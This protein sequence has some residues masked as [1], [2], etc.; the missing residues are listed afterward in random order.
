MTRELRDIGLIVGAPGVGKTTTLR[1]YREQN[2]NT[3]YCLMNPAVASMSAALQ[4]ICKALT[5]YSPQRAAEI[6]HVMCNATEW[7]QGPE[8]LIIDEA[9]HLNDLTLDSLRCV[10]DETGLPIV[11]AGNHTLRNRYNNTKRASF[12]QFTSRIGPKL[13]LDESTYS[14]IAALAR[15]HGVTDR[16]AVAFLER[17]S[18]HAGLRYVGKLLAIAGKGGPVTLATLKEASMSLGDGQ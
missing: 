7:Q 5:G 2:P 11:F 6:H 17:H 10:N 1:W 13:F 14:D 9:Q 12:A 8:L 16:K 15:H 3:R 4:L 18:I